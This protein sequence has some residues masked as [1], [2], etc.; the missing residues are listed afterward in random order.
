IRTLASTDI[1]PVAASIGLP[2]GVA[3]P[4]TTNRSP[5]EKLAVILAPPSSGYRAEDRYEISCYM[6][7]ETFGTYVPLLNFDAG[8][9]FIDLKTA[10]SDWSVIAQSLATWASETSRGDA[11]PTVELF[12]P[13]EL[14]QEL[15]A[16]DFLNVPCLTEL[17][18]DFN[19]KS[20]FSSLCPIVVR[21]VDRYLHPTLKKNVIHLRKKFS[22]LL[23]GNGRWICDDDAA[24]CETLIARRDVPQ[25][26]AV[27]MVHSLPGDEMAVWLKWLIGSMVPVALWWAIDNQVD[28]EGHL[29][30]YKCDSRSILEIGP[31]GKVMMK[32]RDLDL[33]PL[34]RKRLTTSACSLVLML[35]NPGLVPDHLIPPSALTPPSPSY[36]VCSVS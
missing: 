29:L 5:I 21:P 7:A 34:E 31:E 30:K 26:V 1:A 3:R 6:K 9:E 18:D 2:S 20:S 22:Q 10:Y 4:S 24:S 15:L 14:L 32:A 33:L 27:R 16:Q 19:G 11:P 25:D 35:D 28:R 23:D 13:Y 8:R 17:D 36:T 12:L